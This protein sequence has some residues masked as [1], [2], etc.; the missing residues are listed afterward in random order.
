LNWQV[1]RNLTLVQ[2]GAFLALLMVLFLPNYG[3]EKFGP[4]PALPAFLLSL[5]GMWL[6]WRERAVLFTSTAQRR[7]VIVFLLL[8][9][10]VML[11]VP[12]SFTPRVSASIAA[13]LFLYFFTGLTLIHSLRADAERGRL[14]KWIAVIVVFWIADA[15]VQII[16]GRDLFGIAINLADYRVVGPFAGNLRLSLFIVLFL[17]T[18]MLWLL[19]RGWIPTFTVFSVA[20]VV[21]MLSGSR[22][23]LVFLV[24]VAAGLFM[25]LPGGRRKWF[26]AGALALICAV[27]VATSPVLLQRF[28]LFSELRHPS[29]ASIN[30]VLSWRLWIWDTALNMV[31]A[32]PFTG[33]GVGAFQAVY[34]QYSTMPDDVFR[35][36]LVYHAHQLYVGIAAE[37]G[38]IGL[39]ALCVVVGLA[40][41]W[42]AMA[43][44][45]RRRQAWPFALGLL[46]YA[47]PINSQPVLLSQ[48]LFPVIL[49]LFTNMLAALDK[50]AAG[51]K[52]AKPV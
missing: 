46:V 36:S 29:F 5:L 30:H 15:T 43:M 20:G 1:I 35:G 42:Y 4:N 23:T 19:P 3:I 14:L 18:V 48:W 13:V 8:F 47:F 34:D 39:L 7:W 32:H 41:R 25:K 22:A 37:T 9:V 12:G 33:V 49:L 28:E 50:P 45:D 11:S 40:V 24:I 26:V 52:L 44:P 51:E 31:A 27:A 2:V 6:L 38:L 17:P 10:P 16:F 21:A